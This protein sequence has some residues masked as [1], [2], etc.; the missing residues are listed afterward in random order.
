MKK[1]DKKQEFEDVKKTVEAYGEYSEEEA[2]KKAENVEE[3][4]T[5]LI[6]KEE[7]KEEVNFLD[8]RAKRESV[9]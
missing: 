5:K 6:T 7:V 9:S 8:E 1:T 3:I 2:V 4:V